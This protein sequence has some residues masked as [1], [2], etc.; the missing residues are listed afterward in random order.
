[1]IDRNKKDIRNWVLKS[2]K[3]TVFA[4]DFPEYLSEDRLIAFCREPGGKKMEVRVANREF[5]FLS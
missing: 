3:F 5:S 2:I 1:M 4:Y